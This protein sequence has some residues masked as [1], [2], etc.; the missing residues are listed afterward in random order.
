MRVE[1]HTLILTRF[2]DEPRLVYAKCSC[3]RSI[4]RRP[5]TRTEARRIHADH[6]QD[7]LGPDREDVA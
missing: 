1:L 3:G 5:T 6:V 2:S 7:Q 4:S